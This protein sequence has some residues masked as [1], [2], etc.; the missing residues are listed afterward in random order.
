MAE[1]KFKVTVNGRDFDVVVEELA[2]EGA[3]IGS[4]PVARPALSAPAPSRPPA[5]SAPTPGGAPG[6]VA[7]PMAGKVLKVSV[8]VGQKVKAG[9]VIVVLE[10]MKMETNV[11]AAVSGEIKEVMVADGDTVEA[12]A[13]LVRCE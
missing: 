9:D 2:S 8:K 1:R 12:G 4:A 6:L 5:P 10:A 3:P 11:N 13:A 7:A